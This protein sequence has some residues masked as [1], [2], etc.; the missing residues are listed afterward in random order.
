MNKESGVQSEDKLAG[1][2][3]GRWLLHDTRFVYLSDHLSLWFTLTN[4]VSSFN[5]H[6]FTIL[7]ASV[8]ELLQIVKC[9]Y[10][11][12]NSS[13]LFQSTPVDLVPAQN[14]VLLSV[15]H[16]GKKSTVANDFTFGKV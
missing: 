6:S 2:A 16:C 5:V 14:T 12:F 10:F 9:D 8:L 11:L 7:H 15:T 13:R 1:L 4:S 3:Y